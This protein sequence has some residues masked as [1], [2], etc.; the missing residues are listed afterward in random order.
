MSGKSMLGLLLAVIGIVLL[1][2]TAFVT[3][4]KSINMV[5]LGLAFG[6]SGV[7]LLLLPPRP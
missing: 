4:S 7:T 1:L 6:L 5:S 3:M 2:V